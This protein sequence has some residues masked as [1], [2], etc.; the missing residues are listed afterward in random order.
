MSPSL[1]PAITPPL[2]QKVL[3]SIN[4]IVEL[5]P[6]GIVLAVDG[7]AEVLRRPHA[8][9]VGNQFI[10]VDVK[11][12]TPEVSAREELAEGS[13]AAINCTAA[14]VATV[15]TLGGG[16]VAPITGGTSLAVSVVAAR[17]AVKVLNSA[18][19]NIPAALTGNI[20]RQ[21]AALLTK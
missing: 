12:G 11:T 18:G 7:H 3:Q 19:V 4:S 1:S 5:R 6:L 21:Q 17:R 15:V 10:V 14:V 16:I 20:N 8:E 2:R 13:M 9:P